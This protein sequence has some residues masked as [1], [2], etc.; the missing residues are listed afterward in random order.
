MLSMKNRQAAFW[1]V[2]A[3]IYCGFSTAHALMVGAHLDPIPEFTAESS[4]YT[5]VDGREI[6][7]WEPTQE[8]ILA[9][10][11]RISQL[12]TNNDRTNLIAA[13]SYGFAAVI[14]LGCAYF[15]HRES[16]RH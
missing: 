10:N 3:V 2:I 13:C 12:N 11:A 7:E 16:H 6:G 14:A 8:A 4:Q 5:N 9:T 15:A 1:V